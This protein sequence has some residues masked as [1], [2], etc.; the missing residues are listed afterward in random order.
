MY[1]IVLQC[2]EQPPEVGGKEFGDVE[3]DDGEG[4]CDA[5]L[6][7]GVEHCYVGAPGAF[8]GCKERD[9]DEYKE[10]VTGR[11]GRGIENKGEE[12]GKEVTE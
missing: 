12:G 6:A 11:R 1:C 5:K 4:A 7:D 10:I 8:T 2:I 9:V 3:E